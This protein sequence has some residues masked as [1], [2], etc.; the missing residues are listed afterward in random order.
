MG[1]RSNLEI[2]LVICFL[3][4]TAI[5]NANI[6]GEMAVLVAQSSRLATEFQA[7]VDEANTAMSNIELQKDSRYT[8]RSYLITTQGTHHEQ[9][10]LREF[11]DM[12]SP[13]LREKVAISIFAKLV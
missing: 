9:T 10:E 3:I 5:L 8:I 11:I 4:G 6:F 12:I 13:D 7:Q 1:P 2:A